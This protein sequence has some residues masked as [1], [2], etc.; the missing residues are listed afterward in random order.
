[1]PNPTQ[2]QETSSTTTLLLVALP[3]YRIFRVSAATGKTDIWRRSLT[4]RV[5]T[6]TP[7]LITENYSCVWGAQYS[8][9]GAK[10]LWEKNILTAI[11]PFESFEEALWYVI[12]RKY[13]KGVVAN[14][15]PSQID[16]VA[17]ISMYKNLDVIKRFYFNNIR[18]R[19]L[20]SLD[21]CR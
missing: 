10:I 16:I 13:G 9:G 21:I 3:F 8:W 20:A 18:S 15:N 17:D 12:D 7:P 1:M 11:A 6:C 4:H 5:H 2:S 14:M 19:S